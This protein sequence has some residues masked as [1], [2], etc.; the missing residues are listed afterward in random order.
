[1]FI[2]CSATH[3]S[4][5]MCSVSHGAAGPSY[6]KFQC[7]CNAACPFYRMYFFFLLQC[8]ASVYVGMYPRGRKAKLAADKARI[9]KATGRTLIVLYI[10]LSAQSLQLYSALLDSRLIPA[11]FI[12]ATLRSSSSLQRFCYFFSRVTRLY[13]NQ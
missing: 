6:R 11:E 9:Y 4:D 3:P 13:K 8:C 10:H 1:M 2:S 7:S 5:R 12:W